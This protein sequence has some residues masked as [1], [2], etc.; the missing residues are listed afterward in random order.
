MEYV[1]CK[2]LY[3]S[4][5]KSSHSVLNMIFLFANSLYALFLLAIVV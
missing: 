4:G 1:N 5:L 3:V 2:H